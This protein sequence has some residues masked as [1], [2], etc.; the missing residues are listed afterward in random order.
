MSSIVKEEFEFGGRKLTL[1]TGSLAEQAH[2][3]VL[4]RYGDTIVLSTVVYAK[5]REDLDY[6]PLRV[7]YEERLYAGG[8]IKTSRFVKRE[9][10]P[11]DEAVLIGRL[12][13]RSIRPLFPEE[14][15]N[16]IQ[17]I[18]TVLS[19]D[20]DND[21]AILSLLATSAAIAISGVPWN[22]PVGVVK[23]GHKE[24]SF[25]LNPQNSELKFSDL[26]LVVAG[27]KEGVVM[28]EAFGDQVEEE[29]VF[30]GVEFGWQNLAPLIDFIDHFVDKVNPVPLKLEGEEPGVLKVEQEMEEF[31]KQNF[32]KDFFS[33]QSKD[34][35]KEIVNTFLEEAFVNFEGRGNKDQLTEVFTKVTKH[36]FRQQILA[37]KIRM[38]GRKLDEVRPVFIEVGLLPR[39]HGSAMFK[40]GATQ[41]LSI[42]TLGSTSLEQ[43]IERMTGEET[44]RYIH[45]Y[46]APPFSV[47]EPGRLGYP[48]RR[49][50]G[51]GAL[52]EKAIVPLIPPEEKFPYTIRLV[53]EILSQEGST[54]M[55][56][57]CG[58]SLA[59]MDAGVPIAA[60]AAGVAVGLI[61]E[62]NGYV[63]LTDIKGLED[64][65][66]DMDFKVAGT[67]SGMTAIQMDIKLDHLPLSIF[68]E[69][70]EI[71]RRG[72]EYILDQMAK[73]IS[74]PRPELSEYAPQI[75][76]IQ[77]DP[78][79]IGEV[80]GTGGKVIRGIQEETGAIIDIK[81]DGTVLI[82]TTE[83][84][85]AEKAKELIEG[86]VKEVKVGET[87]RGKVTRV[88][89]FG[90]FVEVLP[91]K[92]GLVHI[93]ELGPG[94]IRDIH[95]YVKV[96]D[97]IEVKV[98]SIDEKGRINLGR[99]RTDETQEKVPERD[100]FSRP[101]GYPRRSSAT[102]G[103][104]DL[105]SR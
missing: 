67:K 40:R 45:H 65:F 99:R 81:D 58:S 80:I 56:A 19:V 30:R 85:G 7:D 57:V 92:E 41:T 22:G 64:S 90:A 32:P 4:A 2:G 20:Q 49:E 60:P 27:K 79:K 42:A 70:L 69:A 1:E 6:F 89:D 73:V 10:R 97:T 101:A 68:K 72:R 29:V 50:I 61:K 102:R 104:K 21:P 39:T 8:K 74:S 59:L 88:V 91:G 31:V 36:L 71:A 15:I 35:R 54:S 11:S 44:K 26:D 34:V 66:G 95:Q 94:F 28:I 82:A 83:K 16:E 17:V 63:F 100:T 47:G 98:V 38:D 105:R 18:V 24:S 78:S 93:S 23:V 51:H 25:L 37:K 53:S 33:E 3:A 62:G 96:G 55:A 12:I 46:N 75:T 86:I 103:R 84:D 43:L 13:D 48:G 9:G 87:Y 5:P 77:I 14:F 52:A 76:S